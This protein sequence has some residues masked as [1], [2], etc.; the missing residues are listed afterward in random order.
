MV[1]CELFP[2]PTLKVWDVRNCICHYLALP[3]RAMYLE[4]LPPLAIYLDVLPPPFILYLD[5][6]PPPAMRYL[7]VMSD[8]A[9]Y[10]GGKEDQKNP[11]VEAV[12]NHAAMAK[13][14]ECSQANQMT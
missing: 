1:M 7:E 10:L 3:P 4:V 12:V 2:H 13:F 6:L 5:V 8:Y 9:A 14:K 11:D